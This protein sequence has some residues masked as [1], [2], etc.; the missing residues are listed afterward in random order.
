MENSGAARSQTSLQN[1]SSHNEEVSPFCTA[2]LLCDIMT[3]T[4]TAISSVTISSSAAT[5]G[6]VGSKCRDLGSENSD[7]SGH[8][9]HIC[10]SPLKGGL[11]SRFSGCSVSCSPDYDHAIRGRQM[12]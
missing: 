2:Y 9:A 6:F 8:N 5:S 7:L 10:R 4:M 3:W 12:D 1:T 11:G